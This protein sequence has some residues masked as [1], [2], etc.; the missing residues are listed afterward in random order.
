MS[1]K[2]NGLRVDLSALDEVVQKLRWLVDE[3]SGVEKKAKYNTNLPPNAFG[4][5]G[6]TASN[7][8]AVAFREAGDL[9]AAHDEMKLQLEKI[10]K[11]LNGLIDKF[12]TD[13]KKVRDTY[14]NQE[15]GV[16][17]NMGDGSSG[18]NDGVYG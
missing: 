3:T 16:K 13:T 7:G 10:I 18:S 5:S 12:G 6:G 8:D 14:A 9:Y 15:H 2:S 4:M 17:R 1:D 11:K